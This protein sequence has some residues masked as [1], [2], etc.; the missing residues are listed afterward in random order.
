MG[1]SGMKIQNPIQVKM[2][3][4]VPVHRYTD[5]PIDLM[6][7][8]RK[9]T[10]ALEVRSRKSFIP[11][12]AEYTITPDANGGISLDTEFLT[13]ARDFDLD[14][15]D[16]FATASLLVNLNFAAILVIESINSNIPLILSLEY[17]LNF[18]HGGN[19]MYNVVNLDEPSWLVTA[20]RD[21]EGNR[22][23][24]IDYCTYRN[25]VHVNTTG[26]LRKQGLTQIPEWSAGVSWTSEDNLDLFY[27]RQTNVNNTKTFKIKT[28]PISAVIIDPAIFNDTI[29]S[30]LVIVGYADV[31][32]PGPATSGTTN[33]LANEY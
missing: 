2:G 22:V 7:E 18:T 9:N 17:S 20:F 12:H 19:Y 4:T 6:A 33:G 1:I 25:I 16:G 29:D 13:M 8:L 30:K 15:D 14:P 31:T 23:N 3:K 32:Q 26:E 28:E 27:F 24:P 21:Y 10:E 11:F 5:T